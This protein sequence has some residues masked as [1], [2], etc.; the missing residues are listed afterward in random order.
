MKK[1]IHIISGASAAQTVRFMLKSHNLNDDEVF[2]IEDDL[3]VG[4]LT[5]I[6]DPLPTARIEFWKKLLPKSYYQQI[7]DAFV[8]YNKTFKFLANSNSEIVIW[9]GKNA[10]EILNL[11]R[12]CWYFKNSM[13]IISEVSIAAG[14]I[15]GFGNLQSSIAMLNPEHQWQLL[16]QQKIITHDKINLYAKNWQDILYSDG[17]R[18]WEKDELNSLP[19]TYYDDMILACI[20]N[21]WQSSAKVI[22]SL[23]ASSSYLI[24]DNFLWWRLRNLIAQQLVQVD[25]EILEDVEPRN[26]MVRKNLN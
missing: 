19:I 24:G 13:S 15:K 11:W 22:G 16:Q 9:Y 26:I 3:S 18:V 17:V 10:S 7:E 20:D 8:T 4:P 5:G 21:D 14:N 6:D 12:V 25:K 1:V 23:M 2:V